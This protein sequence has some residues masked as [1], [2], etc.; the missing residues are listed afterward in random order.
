MRPRSVP[1]VGAVAVPADAYVLDVREPE[2]WSAGH[3]PDAVHLP[4]GHLP[5]RLADVPA[6]REVVVVC[7]VGS[8]SAQA[9]A[10]LNAHGRTAVNLD[11]GMIA[12]AAAG[13]P[14][15]SETGGP[16]AVA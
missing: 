14:M 13:R 5:A 1:S 9:T 4:L 15:V 7:R 11:G 16:P 6:D 10:F 12:W 8:R 2:E 3:V